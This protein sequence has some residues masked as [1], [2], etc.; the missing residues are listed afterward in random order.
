MSDIINL[1]P[2]SVAN[3]I[4]A[5]EVIQRPASVVKELVENSVDAGSTSIIVNI[6]E[7]GKN[8]IQISD[9]GSG[10]SE[11]DARMAFERHATSK[12]KNANDLF[13]IRTM[14]FRGEA[15]ASIAA[16]ANV[17][18]KTKKKDNDLGVAINISGSEVISQEPVSCSDGSNFLIKNLFFNVP[19]RRKFLKKNS[20]ELKH[21]ITEF[22]RIALVHP[23]IAM[24]LQHNDAEIYNLPISNHHE[25]IVNIFGKGIK[26]NLISIETE[27]T[28]I[29]IKGFIGK[30][31]FARKTSGEQYFFINDRYMKHPYFY[32]AVLLAYE[33]ILPP[34]TVPSFFLYFDADPSTI[35]INIHPTKTEIKFEDERA[36]WQIVQASVK[37][38]LGKFNI[39]PS[40]DF[41]Q[42]S[43]L[44]IDYSTKNKEIR[45]P[46]IEINHSYNPFEEEQKPRPNSSSGYSRKEEKSKSMNWESLYSGFEKSR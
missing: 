31:E 20:T 39:V 24:T 33:N 25:R 15:L 43:I 38:S 45:Q 36:I 41:D 3:Q 28:V 46:S 5:G 44:D 30:P 18:L 4:A 6:R 8:L 21:I 37:Q 42:E 1:L 13:A 34:D 35:D 16:I 2:D 14:G 17:E 26:Q 9:N 22:Q 19:A 11:T 10:M 23:E 27:T 29:S 32:K 40:I 7:A 12:I